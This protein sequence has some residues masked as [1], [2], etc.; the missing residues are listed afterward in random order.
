MGAGATSLAFVDTLLTENKNCRIIIVDRYS[1][2]G[3]HWTIAYPFA[4]LHQPASAYG[5]NS[6]R[7]GKTD[8]LDPTN[9]VSKDEILS[10]YKKVLSTFIKT[11]RVRYFP[12]CNADIFQEHI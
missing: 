8:W 3:G 7:L 10:Y 12:Q 6:K 2:P 1:I 4:Q 5:V 11:G 9:L